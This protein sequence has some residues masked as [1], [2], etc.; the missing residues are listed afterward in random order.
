MLE[1]IDNGIVLQKYTQ[2]LHDTKV[3]IFFNLNAFEM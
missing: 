2:Y 3:N 1:D